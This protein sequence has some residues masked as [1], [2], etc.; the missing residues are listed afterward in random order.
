[1]RHTEAETVLGPLTLVAEGDALTAIYFPGHW[2]LPKD[3]GFGERVGSP[4]ADPL[5]DDAARQLR[6]YLAGE[7]RSFELTTAPRGND[8]QL[9]VWEMLLDIPYGG[10]T[11]YGALADRLG[12]R[13]L[14]QT[15]GQAVGHNPLSIVIP[16]H[17]VVGSDGSLTGYAGGLGR[18]RFLLELEEP[19][20]AKEARLF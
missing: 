7:R 16:C 15:V 19:P 8:F 12:G 11:T 13:G 10:T 17:R 5:F 3:A 2:T 4:S 20:E 18:K 14:A 1:M 6:E 9:A